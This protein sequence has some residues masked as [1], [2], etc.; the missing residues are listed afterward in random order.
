MAVKA[1]TKK[2]TRIK[3]ET[4]RSRPLTHSREAKIK[5]VV[6]TGWGNAAV[7]G[8]LEA[9][10]PEIIPTNDPR[11]DKK[12][13]S[14]LGEI[15]AYNAEERGK[16][17]RALNSTRALAIKEDNETMAMVGLTGG[18]DGVVA[19]TLDQMDM[20]DHPD[21][22]Y[23]EEVRKIKTRDDNGNVIYR[24][25]KTS[26]WISGTWRL[27]DPMI[28]TDDGSSF[29]PCRNADATMRTDLDMTKQIV[30]HGCPEAFIS[31]WG[32]APGA[33]KSKLAVKACKTVIKVTEE[34]VLYINGEA[35]EEQFRMWV[36]NDVDPE[37]FRVINQKLL[38]IQTVIDWAY[39]IKPRLIVIDSV[40]TLAEWNM[41]NSGQQ[42]V[43][44]ILSDLKTDDR[45]GRPH[46]ILISQLNKAGDLKGSRDLEHLADAVAAVTQ[47][48]TEHVSQFEIPRKN[49]A[50]ATPNGTLFKHMRND[51]ELFNPRQ[52]LRT[53]Y[54][55]QV[56]DGSALSQGITDPPVPSELED[57]EG[58]DEGSEDTE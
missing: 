28:P 8:A 41:G 33:G 7:W 50:A 10:Y 20:L 56:P 36:G 54:S 46:I 16:I 17:S 39:R 45:A 1:K 26:T 15:P 34:A 2:V 31:I 51:V 30:E 57:E 6:R 49:R 5:M 24:D 40:Q 48:E 52:S 29:E 13:P 22:K 4:T 11:R 43:M 47:T 37:L 3:A 18:L 9:E 19:K 42:S 32:G 25:K 53:Q 44:H 23:K 35:K 27:G 58:G 38:P 14:Y 21:S 55:L 12:S